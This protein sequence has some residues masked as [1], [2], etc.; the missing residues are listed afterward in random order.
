MPPPDDRD[1]YNSFALV[2]SRVS[3]SIAYLFQTQYLPKK[4]RTEHHP[5][6]VAG[7]RLKSGSPARTILLVYKDS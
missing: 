2:R 4:T 5:R 3:A 7:Y 6:V 1:L